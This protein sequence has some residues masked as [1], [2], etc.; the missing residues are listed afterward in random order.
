MNW[1]DEATEL[2][3]ELLAYVP[4]SMRMKV[5]ELSEVRAEHL[6][7]DAGMKEVTVELAV[8]ALVECTPLR[9]RPRLREALAFK[10][11]DCGK[12]ELAFHSE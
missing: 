10:K 2:M 3:V 11:I 4:S 6:A 12:Y 1:C 8:A 9:L 5:E 7:S